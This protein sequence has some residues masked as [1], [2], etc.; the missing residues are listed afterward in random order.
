MS[1][2]FSTSSSCHVAFLRRPMRFYR[3]LLG[4]LITIAINVRHERSTNNKSGKANDRKAL[5][6]AFWWV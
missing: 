5:D 2:D 6:N 1:K 3:Y 4:A